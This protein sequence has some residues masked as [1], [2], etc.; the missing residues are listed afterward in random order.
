[1]DIRKRQFGIRHPQ[2]KEDRYAEIA[3]LLALSSSHV[4]LR[5]T[6]LVR[7]MI[8]ISA[9]SYIYLGEGVVS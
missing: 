4:Q 9:R 2:E 5:R 6:F 8:L 1:M 3:K 7:R